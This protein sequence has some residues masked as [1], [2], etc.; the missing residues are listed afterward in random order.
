MTAQLQPSEIENRQA[1]G[2]TSSQNSLERF[3]WLPCR[4]SLEIP[5]SEFTI[6]D[7]LRLQVGSVVSTAVPSTD[8]VPLNVN[9]QLLAWIQFEMIGDRVAAR[10]TELA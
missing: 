1:Q 9:Q 8:E 7:L 4:L 10:I 2:A 3:E 6:G 5:V